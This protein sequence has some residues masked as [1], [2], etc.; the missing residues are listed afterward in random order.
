LDYEI[1]RID[2]R[3]AHEVFCRQT[4]TRADYETFSQACNDIF[5]PIAS[6]WAVVAQLYQAGYRLGILSNTCEGHW[7]HCLGRYNLLRAFFAVHALSFEI[8]ALKPDAA[9]FCKAVELAGCR[10]EEVFYVDDIAGH[11]A[12]ARA[13]GFD[14]VQYT[15]TLELVRELRNRGVEFNY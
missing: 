9:I 2:S 15:T 6:M 13:V 12:G 7:K 5:T 1:G 14:A 8:G 10:P 11:V 4:G 3:G